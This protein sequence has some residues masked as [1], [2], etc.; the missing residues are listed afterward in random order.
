MPSKR[1]EGTKKK[2]G[3][4]DFGQHSK[5]FD[6]MYEKMEKCCSGKQASIDCS[7]MMDEMKRKMMEKCC[8]SRG[9]FEEADEQEER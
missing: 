4:A 7:A 1:E 3:Q 6:E 8:G 9:E 2:A 5:G